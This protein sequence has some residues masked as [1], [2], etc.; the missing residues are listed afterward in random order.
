MVTI[1]KEIFETHDRNSYGENFAF[2]RIL[3][4]QNDLSVQP[5]LPS[6]AEVKD[7]LCKLVTHCNYF[8]R[9]QP[10]NVLV[11]IMYLSFISFE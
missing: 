4:F 3:I 9:I 6:S 5:L 1:I 8:C 10:H 7:L 2:V 11:K